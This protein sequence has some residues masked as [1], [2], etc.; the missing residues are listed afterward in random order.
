VQ[1]RAVTADSLASRSALLPA[2]RSQP[3][4]PNCPCAQ[5]QSQLAAERFETL[6]S[7]LTASCTGTVTLLHRYTHSLAQVH[8]WQ[9]S[10]SI[11][12]T[13]T[14]LYLRLSHTH[15]TK[16]EISALNPQP[17][18]PT[19]KAVARSCPYPPRRHNSAP[20]TRTHPVHMPVS[21]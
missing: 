18:T 11:R 5:G 10:A 16:F 15:N 17:Q 3:S 20:R 19:S 7:Q 13:R 4:T 21:C 6:Q 9:Q 12:P 1:S 14:S 8:S 2:V